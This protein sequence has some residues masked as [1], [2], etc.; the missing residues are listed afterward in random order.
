MGSLP[1][2]VA[3]RTVL[4]PDGYQFQD[5]HLAQPI[6]LCVDPY[7]PNYT[8]TSLLQLTERAVGE[9]QL[10]DGGHVPLSIRGLCDSA[11]EVNVVTWAALSPDR[12]GE[13]EVKDDYEGGVTAAT[14]RLAT[15]MGRP[16]DACL[17][18]I[19]LHE[20]GH[21]LGI[22]HQPETIVSVMRAPCGATLSWA[23]I[24]AVRYLYH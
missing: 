15:A 4:K 22:A 21:V 6:E 10:A 14:I 8:D 17:M 5:W 16:S 7:G 2:D 13:A 1:S 3:Q 12:S 23:D 18:T 11:D 9:W 20:V 24:A 19:L